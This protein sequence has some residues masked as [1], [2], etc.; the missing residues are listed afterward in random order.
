MIYYLEGK[1]AQMSPTHVVVDCN[2]VGYLAH[3]SLHTYSAIIKKNGGRILTYLQV[4]EDGQVLYGFNDEDERDLFMLLISVNGVGCNTARMI[5]SSLNPSE[6]RYAILNGNLA[7]IKGVK[8]IGD[9]TAQRLIIELKDKVGKGA[10]AQ[11]T[12]NVILSHGKNRDEAIQALTMLGFSKQQSE[13]AMDK[14]A[15][16]NAGADLSVEQLIKQ[17]LNNI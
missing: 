16:A 7:L 17:A 11:S 6:L 2:G 10:S 13:K 12:L 5:L 3:I 1:F 4:K 15:K 8:G 14:V 9:K